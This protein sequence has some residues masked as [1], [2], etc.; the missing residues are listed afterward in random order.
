M[1]LSTL[2]QGSSCNTYFMCIDGL[3]TPET[4]CPS[5]HLF[6]SVTGSCDRPHLVA[7]PKEDYNG[8]LESISITEE[9]HS[10]CAQKLRDGTVGFRNEGE[11]FPVHGVCGGYGICHEGVLEINYCTGSIFI[12]RFEY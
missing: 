10:Y 6:N 1:E 2:C 3:Q 12:F 9:Y 7:C 5:G 8:I 4:L 11:Y